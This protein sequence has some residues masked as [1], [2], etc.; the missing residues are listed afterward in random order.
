MTGRYNYPVVVKARTGNLLDRVRI[1]APTKEAAKDIFEYYYTGYKISY[2]VDGENRW[3][4]IFA[5]NANAATERLKEETTGTITV[6]RT[7]KLDF[8]YTVEVEGPESA[9][10]QD[11]R[12]AAFDL[13]GYAKNNLPEDVEWD[14]LPHKIQQQ[15]KIANK[16]VIQYLDE[17]SIQHQEVIAELERLDEE[18]TTDTNTDG[19]TADSK[20]E[21][22]GKQTAWSVDRID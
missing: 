19:D 4:T 21:S 7:E 8:E 18:A 22:N 14:D 5:K 13:L 20:V 1:N 17:K 11:H 12:P 16:T 3:E 2:S 6:P 15:V 9:E 10:M